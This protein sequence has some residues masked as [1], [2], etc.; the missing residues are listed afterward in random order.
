MK[1]RYSLQFGGEAKE[2]GEWFIVKGSSPLASK[3]N[4]VFRCQRAKDEDDDGRPPAALRAEYERLI[5]KPEF[6]PRETM[7]NIVE[8]V[9]DQDDCAFDQPCAFGHRVEQHAVYCHNDGWLY[10]PGKCGRRQMASDWFG[11]AWPHEKCP[12]FKPNPNWLK[13]TK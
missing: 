3:R 11:T 1:Y 6:S 10:A 4:I 7:C 9:A 13:K 2:G 12:G 8:M 5:G